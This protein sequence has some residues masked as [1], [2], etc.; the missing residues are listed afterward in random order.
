MGIP[1]RWWRRLRALVARDDFDREL[2]EELEFHLQMET[3]RLIEAGM[4]PAAARRR[5]M[6]DFGGVQKAREQVH[7]DRWGGEA[8]AFL[9][10]ARYALRTLVRS[11]GY[12][13]VVIVTVALTVG[14]VTTVASVVRGSLVDPLPYPEADRLVRVVTSWEGQPDGRSSPAELLDLV[15]GLVSASAVGGY[16]YGGLTLQEGDLAERLSVAVVTSGVLPAL[17]VGPAL[18]RSF[19][20]QD[21]LV[22]EF[23]LLVT[24][25]F[26]RQQ[27]GADPAAVGRSIRLSGREATVVGVLPPEFRMPDRLGGGERVDA[28]LANEFDP[29]TI[30]NRGSHYLTVV[31]RLRSDTN[32]ATARAELDRF[33]SVMRA[34][35]PDAYPE[36]MRLRLAYQS[37]RDW[38]VGDA[39]PA[40]FVLAGAVLVILL[41]AC[42]NLAA[43]CLSRYEV[44]HRELT[45]RAALGAGRGRLANLVLVESVLA[46]AVGGL[47][48]LALASMGV[49]LVA[50]HGPVSLPRI[51]AIDLDLPTALGALIVAAITGAAFGLLPALAAGRS[52]LPEALGSGRGG[53]TRRGEQLR[54]A[55]VV[56]QIALAMALLVG[57][58]LLGSTLLALASTDPGYVTDGVVTGRVS[59]PSAAYEGDPERIDLFRSVVARLRSGS[60]VMAAGAVTSLPLS[61][62]L[63]DLG[64]R[65]EGVAYPADQSTPSADWQVIVPGYFEAMGIEL[66]HGRSIDERDT[67]EVP[68]V[69]VVNE[70]FAATWLAGEDPL[71]RRFDLGGGALPSP[72]T[73]IG[74]VRD[75]SHSSLAADERAEMYLPHAQFRHWGS[76]A[77]MT[78]MTFVI[79]S[80]R[81]PSEL[82]DLLRNSV[83]ER[84]PRLAVYDIAAMSD[85]RAAGVARERFLAFVV[86]GF[87]LVA[88]LLAAV[89]VYGVVSY[90]VA[91][92]RREMGIRIALG[93]RES[94]IFRLVVGRSLRLTAIGLA[95]GAG[96]ALAGARALRGLLYG[97]DVLDP[98]T[99]TTVIVA[100]GTVAL[101]G[102]AVPAVRALHG[103]D[104]LLRQD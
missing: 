34:D 26:W 75:V 97:V 69:V 49:D 9:R 90:G 28:L 59:L 47:A 95:L 100:L 16:S 73:V 82:V 35:H 70:T 58:G 94:Q 80:D 33:A 23:R 3:R 67:A 96:L 11:P 85:V 68:G 14:A 24:D 86:S 25:A 38:I 65:L 61:S 50:I 39:R 64:F 20:S 74:V 63:G 78:A 46:A 103:I 42:T 88:L 36:D 2:Q 54:Q 77:A 76:Q 51:D 30:D 10:D 93:A 98:V 91:M 89:G 27:L 71:G 52:S 48:G 6:R 37:A 18:G 12:T 84:D 53:V 40:L 81:P 55:L 72:V 31:A 102:A 79:R 22:D 87:A 5:A 15:D 32:L 44:R 13:L 45:L 17:G 57:A 62:R 8:A 1:G 4:E 21:G 66:V 41:V 60:G 29:A 101:A 83:R 43:L 104:A 19:T 92:R 99:L 7:Q 56:A